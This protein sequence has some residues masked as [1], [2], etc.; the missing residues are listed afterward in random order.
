MLLIR[1]LTVISKMR[2]TMISILINIFI[3]RMICLEKKF[4]VVIYSYVVIYVE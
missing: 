3:L 2:L 4:L 1:M